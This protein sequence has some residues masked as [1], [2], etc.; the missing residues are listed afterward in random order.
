M[1]PATSQLAAAA[2]AAFSAAVLVAYQTAPA[3]HPAIYERHSSPGHKESFARILPKIELNGALQESYSARIPVHSLKKGISDEEILA[4]FNRG[5]FSGP[6]FTLERWLL[7]GFHLSLHSIPEVLE[8]LNRS[9]KPPATGFAVHPT[10]WSR[11]LSTLSA[12]SIPS[13]GSLFFGNF[14][15]LD[16]SS[17]SLAQRRNVFAESPEYKPPSFP[18]IEW[19]FRGDGVAV[20]SSHRFEVTRERSL[21]G[22]AEPE[23]FVKITFSHVSCSPKTG[24]EIWG[25]RITALHILYSK[26]LFSDGMRQVLHE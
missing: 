3:F 13:V 15:V 5:F 6:A 21:D 2:V 7:C 19:V 18:F 12:T 4:R 14:L 25:G 9:L 24:D 17:L 22:A 23:D 10:S 1:S 8:A 11:D 20:A 26:C 16:S